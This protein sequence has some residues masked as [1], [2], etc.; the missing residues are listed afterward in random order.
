MAGQLLN[1]AIS[2]TKKEFQVKTKLLYP[3]G[4]KAYIL[5]RDG[6]EK[7]FTILAVFTAFG[8]E[9]D[10]WR[11]SETIAFAVAHNETFTVGASIKTMREIAE[12]STHIAL[13]ETSGESIVYAIRTGDEYKPY[14]MDWSYKYYIRQVGD[15][16]DPAANV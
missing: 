5:K 14:Y 13:V 1:K 16:F 15:R 4:I 2:L 6:R 10:R 11:H 7:S 3:K 8:T 12:I 9:F